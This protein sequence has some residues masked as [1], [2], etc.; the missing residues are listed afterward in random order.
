M[1]RLGVKCYQTLIAKIIIRP[2][3]ER[4]MYNNIVLNL[5]IVSQKHELIAILRLNPTHR[6]LKTSKHIT[7]VNTV[8]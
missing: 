8:E 1:L 7:I 2:N 3:L 4:D 5:V 6:G